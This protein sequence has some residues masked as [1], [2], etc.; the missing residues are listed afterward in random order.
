[1]ALAC[2]LCDGGLAGV[3]QVRREVFG[4][5]FWSHLLAAATPF[6]VIL[7]IVAAVLWGPRRT[8]RLTRRGTDG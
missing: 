2:P 6:G 3:N 8:P 7:G 1:M 4:P 5:E